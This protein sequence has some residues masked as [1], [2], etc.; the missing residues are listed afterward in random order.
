[1]PEHFELVKLKSDPTTEIAFDL[2]SIDSGGTEIDTDS[3]AESLADSVFDDMLCQCLVEH[4][5]HHLEESEEP[6]LEPTCKKARKQELSLLT[7][8]ELVSPRALKKKN[9]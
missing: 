6:T 5:E 9:T 7:P 2:L 3:S 4:Q 8:K 1:M